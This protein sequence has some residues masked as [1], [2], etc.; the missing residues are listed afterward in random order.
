M[1]RAADSA[2]TAIF[3][4]NAVL[5]QQLLVAFAT[6][7]KAESKLHRTSESERSEDREQNTLK[8]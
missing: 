2:S 8:G 5:P 4:V 6:A 7:L 3:R 1:S